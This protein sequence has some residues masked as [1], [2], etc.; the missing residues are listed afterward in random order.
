LLEKLVWKWR[1][2][3][4]CEEKELH[5]YLYLYIFYI[6]PCSFAHFRISPQLCLN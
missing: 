3:N 1:V 6:K 2:I 4:A 5:L